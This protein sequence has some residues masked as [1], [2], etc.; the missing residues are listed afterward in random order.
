MPTLLSE[1]PPL[2]S[3]ASVAKALDCSVSMVYEL[4]KLGLLVADVKIFGDAERGMRW[5][6]ESV[7]A[8]IAFHSVIPA[9]NEPARMFVPIDIDDILKGSSS[10]AMSATRR[11]GNGLRVHRE[12]SPTSRHRTAGGSQ[13]RRTG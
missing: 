1:Y 4:R 11:D 12:D 8:F 13:M 2:M 3:A 5:K 9:D 10:S 6:R 7:E